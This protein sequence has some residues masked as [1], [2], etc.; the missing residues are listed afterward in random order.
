MTNVGILAMIA[1]GWLS[2]GLATHLLIHVPIVILAAAIG[3]WLFFVQHQFEDA[4]WQP[5]ASWDFT[6]SALEG[7]SYY[8]LPRVLQ[9]FTGNIGFHHIHHFDSC[10]PNYNLPDC[11]AAEPAF[12]QVIT[13]GIRDSLKCTR[14]K[15]WDEPSQRMVTFAAARATARQIDNNLGHATNSSTNRRAA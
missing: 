9:W 12:Q 10:I 13:L 15:L 11:Y 8:R 5:H 1:L 14:L 6:R 4:Y 2:I 3:S 7:S